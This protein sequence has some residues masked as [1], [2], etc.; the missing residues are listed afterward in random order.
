MKRK[1]VS[2]LATPWH[3]DTCNNFAKGR[4]LYSKEEAQLK[5]DEKKKEYWL[6]EY[7]G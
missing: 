1:H 7:S 2:I 4:Y 6:L 5:L 3:C